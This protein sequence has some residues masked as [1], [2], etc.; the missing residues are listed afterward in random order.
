MLKAGAG[1][2][3]FTAG[4]RQSYINVTLLRWANSTEG[5][6]TFDVQLLNPTGGASVGVGSTVSVTLLAGTR[7]YGIFYFADDSLSVVVAEDLDSPVVE[8]T[9]EVALTL[10]N[11]FCMTSGV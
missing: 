10:T 4:Q 1:L 7:A 2:L 3:T 5:D 6:R 11:I 9:F 8:A